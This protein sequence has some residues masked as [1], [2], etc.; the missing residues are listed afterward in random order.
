[1]SNEAGDSVTEDIL[2]LE[3]EQCEDEEPE[4][5]NENVNVG[6][7]WPYLSDMFA[8]KSIS[9]TNAKV[10]GYSVLPSTKNAVQVCLLCRICAHTSR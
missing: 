6:H 2:N 10:T 1:M 4:P 7:P 8:I 3:V 9:K 5:T